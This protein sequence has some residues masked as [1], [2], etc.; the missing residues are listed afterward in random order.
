MQARRNSQV[1]GSTK[2]RV[3]LITLQLLFVAILVEPLLRTLPVTQLQSILLAVLAVLMVTLL[4]APQRLLR[5]TWFIAL[6]ALGNSAVLVHTMQDVSTIEPWIMCEF[7]L[8]M[9][10]ISYAPSVSKS[11]GLSG[12]VVGLYALSLYRFGL[13]ETDH[14][15]LLPVLLSV[16]LAFAGKARVVQTEIERITETEEQT[17]YR[18]MTDALTGLPNRALF[19]EQVARAIQCN[20]ADGDAQF[21]ILFIDLDGFKPINDRLGHKAGDAVLR[22]TAKRFQACMRKGDTVGRYGGDEF[23][24][25][26]HHVIGPDDAIRVAER[27]LAKLKEPID[28]GELV[29][30]GASI[31]IA[32]STNLHEQPEDMIRD[33]DGAMYRAKAQ[34]K[35]QYVFSD[36]TRDIPNGE[37]K[38]R[39]KRMVQA[40]W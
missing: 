35:N 6:L 37:L 7:L 39:L 19:L 15:F 10:T 24:L 21:A 38:N 12:L 32:L 27:V 17:R 31:G 4:A 18:T 13:F 23:T 25:L 9:V 34:G 1:P 3:Y 11:V 36:Q 26:V 40:R 20:R 30:V 33:A 16:S 28:I 22:H 5:T 29:M 14:V 2:A 8:L